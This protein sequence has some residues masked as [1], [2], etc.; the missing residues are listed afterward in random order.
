MMFG[1]VVSIGFV[2]LLRFFDGLPEY[3][4]TELV[5]FEDDENFYHCKIVPKTV[6]PETAQRRKTAPPQPEPPRMQSPASRLPSVRQP[7]S[8][9]THNARPTNASAR[10]PRATLPSTTRKQLDSRPQLR[11]AQKQ[12]TEP[13]KD[14]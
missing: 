10:L 13:P 1:S 6:Y 5:T 2:F 7:Q 3:Q 9:T 4:K 8:N 14:E 11:P 12:N